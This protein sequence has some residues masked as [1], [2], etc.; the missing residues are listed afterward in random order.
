MFDLAGIVDM[1]YA[2]TADLAAWQSLVGIAVLAGN[3]ERL[4]CAPL[5]SL[6]YHSVE[7][8]FPRERSSVGRHFTQGFIHELVT[9]EDGCAGANHWESRAHLAKGKNHFASKNPFPVLFLMH[10][11][12]CIARLRDRSPEVGT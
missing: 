7:Q 2:C 9:G 11:P 1:Q 10:G 3:V 8:Q 6:E 12:N 5:P 4:K